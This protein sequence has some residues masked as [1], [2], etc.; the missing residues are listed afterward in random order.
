MTET[1]M[2]WYE[3]PPPSWNTLKEQTISELRTRFDVVNNL[4]PESRDRNDPIRLWWVRLSN[5][6]SSRQ[7]DARVERALQRLADK[8][9]TVEGF[10]KKCGGVRLGRCPTKRDLG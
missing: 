4:H 2:N 5:A 10:S 8:T 6:L 9:R 1:Q 3:S 7:H